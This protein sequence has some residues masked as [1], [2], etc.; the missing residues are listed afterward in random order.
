MFHIPRKIRPQRHNSF[1]CRI[2][3]YRSVCTDRANTRSTL[4][5]R[6]SCEQRLRIRIT[7]H[8]A[9]H[10]CIRHKFTRHRELAV[11]VITGECNYF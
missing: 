9:R 3:L 6:L 10:S 1:I 4:P 2:H 11:S 7:V 8:R 5:D